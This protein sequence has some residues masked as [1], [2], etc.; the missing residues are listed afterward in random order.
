VAADQRAVPLPNRIGL[1]DLTASL[2]AGFEDFKRFR[3]DV[4]FLCFIYPVVGLVLGKIVLGGGL[5]YLA[6]PLVA[7]FALLGPLFAAGLYEMSRQTEFK[8]SV[9]WANAFDA[10]RSPAIV[11]IVGLG[12]I[13]VALFV[14][15]L[16]AAQLIYA[17]TLAPLFPPGP[18]PS[19]DAFGDALFS[20]GRGTALMV[21]GIGVGFCFAVVVLALTVVSFPLLLDRN[22]SVREAIDT[23]IKAVRENPAPM[24]AWGLI[25][26]GL[27]VLGSVPFLIGLAVVLPILGH[28][29]WHLYR[30]VI[31]RQ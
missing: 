13:L 22:V 4:V 23:S 5:F 3:T 9:T 31:P 21:L 15:W 12:L 17:I 29:T 1:R 2:S 25:V 8:P 19:L 30:R 6:F 11:S 27:M 20:T 26:A 10:F 24:A 14:T 18:P 7:G 16:A 28:A